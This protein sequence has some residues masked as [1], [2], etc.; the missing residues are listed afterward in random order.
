MIFIC[1]YALV[2]HRQGLRVNLFVHYLI[3][4]D[5]L[6]W[7]FVRNYGKQAESYCLLFVRTLN[8]IIMIT[9]VEMGG[10]VELYHS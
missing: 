6:N 8:W 10:F 4:G 1:C 3:C 9:V 7:A 5:V 2:L